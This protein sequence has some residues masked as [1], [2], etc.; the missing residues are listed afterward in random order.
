MNRPDPTLARRIFL[1]SAA[2]LA[3]PFF[4]GLLIIVLINPNNYKPD[5][6]NALQQ[7]TGRKVEIGGRVGVTFGLSP[8]ITL[9][10]V[11]I[12]NPP[13]FS[14]DEMAV[15]GGVEV[16]VSAASLIFGKLHIVR[17]A[18]L[19]VNVL[20]ETNPLG[21]SNTVFT[22]GGGAAP[23]SATSLPSS[24]P[25][26]SGEAA[27]PVTNPLDTLRID[28]I[29]VLAGTFGT[30]DDVRLMRHELVINRAVVRVKGSDQTLSAIGDITYDNA[31]LSFTFE[32]GA[33]GRVFGQDVGPADWPVKA[34]G[35]SASSHL[36]V[37]GFIRNPLAGRGY[38]MAVEATVD[39]LADMSA[40]VGSKLPPIHDLRLNLTMRD[41]NGLPEFTSVLL[42]SG[43]SDLSVYAPGL[44]L[45]HLVLSAPSMDKPMHGDILGR[46]GNQPLTA[47]LDIGATQ[48]LI[49]AALRGSAQVGVSE[50]AV[51]ID[52]DAQIAGA[53]AKLVGQVARPAAMSGL[54]LA[55]NLD[56]PDL[57]AFSSL[58]G[59]KLPALRNLVLS[60]KL[61]EPP[62]G[63]STGVS[64]H[65]LNLAG[66]FGDLTGDVDILFKPRKS[67]SG[68]LGS[69][70]FD[71][72]ALQAASDAVTAPVVAPTTPQGGRVGPAP[73]YLL[74]EANIDFSGL[75]AAD[76]DLALAFDDIQSGGVDYRKVAGHVVLN[77]GTLTVNPF[78]ATLPGGA[79]MFSVAFASQA[80]P[81]TV[82]LRVHAPGVALKPLL[83]AFHQPNDVSGT[84]EIGA[85]VATSGRSLHALASQIT[86]KLGVAMADGE[87]D[88]KLL[89][90]IGA[91]VMR[92]ARLPSDLLSGNNAT[93]TRTKLACVALRID[94]EHGL[95]TLTNM[96]VQT[97]AAQ[98]VGNG[99][100]N[101]GDEAVSLRLRPALRTAVGPSVVVPVR[102]SGM[103]VGPQISLDPNAVA[104]GLV[105]SAKSTLAGGV[106]A[107]TKPSVNTLGALMSDID[108]CPTGLESARNAR[109]TVN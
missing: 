79:M 102:V 25:A 54:D 45:E 68:K 89:G 99:S 24:Q 98:I 16:K 50:A 49:A 93:S 76:V 70:R 66:S 61:T 40:L 84:L 101:F 26:R 13:G 67:V 100:I 85:D 90:A 43:A 106:A 23:M 51:P 10:D 38:Q 44:S 95:A 2:I 35:Q 87:L 3:L 47:N 72:D 27:L 105:T 12:S 88:N 1:V 52:I 4:I 96:V 92:V 83:T 107:L 56:V 28:E 82:A 69:T 22:S 108:P 58:A 11:H 46:F 29:S 78:T 81:P 60:A 34:T 55:V 6:V 53:R 15:V 91:Q 75:N 9:R 104:A 20:V 57:T 21:V 59:K 71:L 36:S 97:S 73:R 8:T 74:S 80:L 63:L 7:A 31:P 64:L 62:S 39:N 14:R 103:L 17:L 33:L 42:R 65:Q 109:P 30:R 5:I 94:A 41:N 32:T 19:N 37:D 86:G 48:S 18:L 77:A